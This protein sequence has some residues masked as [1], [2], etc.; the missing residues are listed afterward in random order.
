MKVKALLFCEGQLLFII[1]LPQM[2]HYSL[3]SLPMHLKYTEIFLISAVHI[4]VCLDIFHNKLLGMKENIT[5]KTAF[6]Q[7]A[8]D[9]LRVSVTSRTV[10][11]QG[12]LSLFFLLD[13]FFITF[14]ML[15]WESPNPPSALLPNPPTPTSWP[16]HYPVL[17]HIIFARPRACPPSD[18][19]LSHLVL[20]MQARDMSSGGT[21]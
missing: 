6:I 18:G 9:C 21:G 5:W 8:Q 10:K 3:A 17:G 14:Q 1:N 12:V 16:W 2:I 15:S 13:I 20:H 4:A 11:E 7:M 19:R